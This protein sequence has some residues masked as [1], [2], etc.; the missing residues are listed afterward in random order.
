MIAQDAGLA[1][2]AQAFAAIANALTPVP[3]FGET[4]FVTGS[5]AEAQW[6]EFSGRAGFD[7]QIDSNNMVYGFLSR[8]YKPGG[9]NPAIPPAFQDTSA[10]T[11]DAEQVTAVETGIKSTLMDGGL[12]LN[13][14]LFSYDY[15]GLQV[16]RLRNNSSINE[17]IDAGIRGLEVEGRW[18]P[19][20]MPG[21]AVDFA[22]GS[23]FTDIKGS[24]SVDPINRTGGD[25]EYVLLNNIDPGSLTGVNYI[26][27]ESQITSALV[28]AAL[29][30][31][32]ALDVRNGL[33]VQSVS[34]PANSSG[35]SIPAY[36]S[37]RFLAAAG[38]E[39]LDGIPIDLDGKTLPNA[40]RHTIKV[41]LSHTWN[42][43]IE[44]LL[45]LRWDYY[46]QSESY[47]REFNTL[48]DEI[49]SWSQHNLSL[50]YESGGNWSAR[51]WVRNVQD[52]E[53]VT[54]KYLTTDTS[55]F[56]RNYF[57]TEPRIFGVSLRFAPGG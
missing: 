2:A 13:G 38:V 31:P 36:F 32:A 26:A 27:R 29:Q 35:V 47:A 54:G 28:A 6:R 4:R 42:V 37:R 41:G 10:F 43:G 21:L 57:L 8:G 40:P 49:D 18:H 25:S 22:Y 55:G 15:T 23:L 44:A 3:G 52:K 14:A 12:V 9:F 50:V 45:T 56:F 34:Y 51:A 16:T 33:T 7:F 39:T 53:I 48:G 19:Q 17:N 11:F 1:A 30:V 20:G 5:P 24:Q 46:W